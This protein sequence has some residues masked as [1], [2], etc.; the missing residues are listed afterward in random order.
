LALKAALSALLRGAAVG[1][2]FG[3]AVQGFSAVV[4][5]LSTSQDRASKQAAN[6]V[7]QQLGDERYWFLLAIVGDVM[8]ICALLG[9]AQAAVRL[10]LKHRASWLR[11]LGWTFALV[12]TLLL[13][14]ASSAPA[15]VVP[16]LPLP[17]DWATWLARHIP[18]W[19]FYA[20]P[21]FVLAFALGRYVRL[22]KLA[23][24]A[25]LVLPF[26]AC[27]HAHRAHEKPNVLIL[28]ADSVRP[29]HMS[30][31]GYDR[32]TT[33]H[34]DQ[35]MK[36]GASFDHA[37]A[38]LAMTTPSWTSILTGRYPHSHG[39]RHMFPDRRSRP[40]SLDALPK[41]AR[42]NGYRTAVISDYAGDFFPIF[43]FGFDRVQTSPPLNTRT[44]FQREVVLRS[45]LA[46]GFL[47]PLPDSLRP[48]IFRYMMNAPD[49]ER[50]ADEILA[51]VDELSD[52]PFFTVA[53]FS[54]THV[55]FAPRAP[56]VS[57]FTRPD[58]NGEHAFSY[59][60]TSIADIARAEN[61][62]TADDAHQLIALYDGALASVDAACGRVLAALDDNTIVLFL[63][64]HGEN[65]FEPGQTT[66]HGK[67]FRGGDEASR[68]PFL[69]R[70]PKIKP[71]VRVAQPVSLVDLAPTLADLLGMRPLERADGRSLL[72]ALKG[73]PLPPKT[74]FAETGAWLNGAPDGDSIPTPPLSE[75]IEADPSDDGQL[76]LRPKYEDLVVI[77][78]HRAL[79]DGDLKL[80]YEPSPIG[81][82]FSL[83]DLK[84]DPHQEHNIIGARADA[85][86]PLITSMWRWLG[87]DPEREVDARGHLVRRAD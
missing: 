8:A 63:A 3:A 6:V 14:R 78:K 2:L 44:L 76:I 15:L 28:A 41:I 73:E 62:V 42:E 75:L 32:P 45:P 56:W 29:D 69:I 40:M 64:D 34:L 47:E 11:D 60:L 39:V 7:N 4:A 10:L 31:F 54:T 87:R 30:G 85:A 22:R 83:F 50:L 77:A 23:A 13:G 82:N 43:D 5:Y 66:L 27:S 33:P 17:H 18:A 36:D 52:Q 51:N 37:L 80:I 79:W 21:L 9:L 12:V 59:N 20:L 55:P 86:A 25:T 24:A 70:G 46:V 71:G 1:A 84:A 61:A 81:A 58:Y 72:P 38:A 48:T 19:F 57:E 49:A 74:V 65:L 26:V 53:F 16:A 35:L 67:W 68:V